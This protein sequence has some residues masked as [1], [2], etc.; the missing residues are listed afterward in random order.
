MTQVPCFKVITPFYMSD[1]AENYTVPRV[2]ESMWTGS[3]GL[4]RSIWI[5]RLGK[6]EFVF[7][8]VIV[9]HWSS[10]LIVI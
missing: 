6:R 2:F 4:F 1:G 5:V 7:A 8:R 9:R 10:E 3:F